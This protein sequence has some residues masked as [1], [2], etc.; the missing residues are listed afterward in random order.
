MREQQYVYMV[1]EPKRKYPQVSFNLD[2]NQCV[3]FSNSDKPAFPT[4]RIQGYIS[5]TGAAP[6]EGNQLSRPIPS[7]STRARDLHPLGWANRFPSR[8]PG[9]GKGQNSWPRMNLTNPIDLGSVN[10]PVD[11]VP[12]IGTVNS[13][14]TPTRTSSRNKP[15]PTNTGLVFQPTLNPRKSQSYQSSIYRDGRDSQLFSDLE[16]YDSVPQSSF[17][18]PQFRQE[19]RH[20]LPID[21]FHRIP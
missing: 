15:S 11:G 18:Q 6:G 7:R 2:Q 19:I 4:K 16:F 1:V 3:E 17:E 5:S 13:P 10:S 20:H 8:F 14:P 12:P 21:M 9:T